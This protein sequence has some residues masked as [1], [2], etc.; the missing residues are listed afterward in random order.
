MGAEDVEMAWPGLWVLWR[1]R[2]RIG[3]S[4]AL[5]A[6]PVD[7]PLELGLVKAGQGQIELAVVEVDQELFQ[8]REVPIPLHLVQRDVQGLLPLQIID[9]ND[10]DLDFGIAAI[11]EDFEALVAADK[12]ARRLIPDQRLDQSELGDRPPDFVIFLVSWLEIQSWVIGGDIDLGDGDALEADIFGVW[13]QVTDRNQERLQVF[14][15]LI[16]VRALFIGFGD[17]G[18]AIFTSLLGF[19]RFFFLFTLFFIFYKGG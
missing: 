10:R 18:A 3:V 1:G 15:Y 17:D 8:G 19:P 11:L 7:H 4:L 6:L 5:S 16:R 2:Y 9:V 12:S 13:F 14:V